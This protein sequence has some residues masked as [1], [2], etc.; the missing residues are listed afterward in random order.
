MARKCW[1]ALCQGKPRSCWLRLPLA[2]AI[3]LPGDC[4]AA[5][6]AIVGDAGA[7]TWLGGAAEPL[8]ERYGRILR[9]E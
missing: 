3:I 5:V 2:R 7:A 6:A 4:V 8:L 9:M 1:V